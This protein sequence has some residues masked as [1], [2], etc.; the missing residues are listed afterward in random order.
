M[1][2]KN[3]IDNSTTPDMLQ[4]NPTDIDSRITTGNDGK[5]SITIQYVASEGKV[6]TSH[7]RAAPGTTV[8]IILSSN[9]GFQC[10]GVS[11]ISGGVRVNLDTYFEASGKI[12][13]EVYTFTMPSQNV[14]L[15]GNFKK[16]PGGGSSGGGSSGG[17]GP[18]GGTDGDNTNPGLGGDGSN[19]GQGSPALP[20]VSGLVGAPFVVPHSDLYSTVYPNA[21]AHNCIYRGKNLG[22]SVTAAQYA[23]IKAGT[24]DDMYI[25]DYWT[26]GGVNYR[27]AAFD[28]YYN[29]GDT[30]C[31]THHVT[32][33]PDDSMYI[34]N[35]ND[36]NTTTGAYVGS[37]MYTKGLNAAKETINTAF[38]AA[39]VLNHRQY[40]QNAVTDSYA[41]S[42]NWYNSTVELMTEQNVYGCKIFG[43]VSNGTAL[44]SNYTIDK[45][46][47]PLFAFRP[48]MISNKA[49]FWLRDVVSSSRFANVSSHG[50][51]SSNFASDTGGVRPAF[52]IIG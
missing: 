3:I 51:A 46:Q 7:D 52:S 25:G 22:T 5:Y 29:T 35:M 15:Q 27:I 28:Y 1:N 42:S 14:V 2:E 23:A 50:I 9:D 24:F 11:V 39:H 18:S 26:I 31:T 20:N 38:G 21:G 8:T 30:A 48:D 34:H 36:T 41:S 43:N 49:W 16:I 40:L 44:P 32:L 37:K 19:N 33:V 6:S 12:V 13:S 17:G 10:N 47:Y 45:S 4:N